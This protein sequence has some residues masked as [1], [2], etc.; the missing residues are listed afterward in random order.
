MKISTYVHIRFLDKVG[1]FIATIM[2]DAHASNI[3]LHIDIA[4]ERQKH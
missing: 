1:L 3:Q 4:D 2:H